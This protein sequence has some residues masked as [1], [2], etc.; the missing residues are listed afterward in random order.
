MFRD[1]AISLTDRSTR[2]TRRTRTLLVLLA[3]FFVTALHVPLLHAQQASGAGCIPHAGGSPNPPSCGEHEPASQADEEN[4]AHGAGN[5]IDLISGNKYQREVDLPALPGTLGLEI[6]RHYNSAHAGLDSPLGL[7]GRGWRLSYETDLHVFGDHIHILQADGR[8]LVF[9]RD[10]EQ[11]QRF[12]STDLQAG[13]VV[14][15]RSLFWQWHWA[16]GR[17]LDFDAAGKLVRIRL[18]DGAAVRLARG[19]RGELMKVTDPQ[20]RSLHLEYASRNHDGFRGVVAIRTPLGRFRYR[21]RDETDHPGRGNLVSMT[22]PDASQRLYHYGADEGEHD[23]RWPHHLT[24]ISLDSAPQAAH[25]EPR[26]TTADEHQADAPAASHHLIRLA[27][28]AYDEHGRAVLS[29]RGQPRQLDASGKPV[30]GTGIEQVE[31]SY[32]ADGISILRNSLGHI[33]RYRHALIHGQARLLEALGPGCARCGPT[34]IRLHYDDYGRVLQ[35]TQLDEQG[36]PLFSLH[37]QRDALGRVSRL[38]AQSHR[39]RADSELQLIARYEYEGNSARLRLLARPS[40]VADAEFQRRFDYDRH[41]QLIRLSEQGFSPLAADGTPTTDARSASTVQ[42]S[43]RFDYRDHQGRLLLTGVEGPLNS[44]ANAMQDDAPRI[45]L[46]W[47]ARSGLPATL[48][49]PGGRRLD[50]IQDADSGLLREVQNEEGRITRIHHDSQQRLRLL[51]RLNADGSQLQHQQWRYDA[52]DHAVEQRD[53][54]HPAASWLRQWNEHG[55]LLFHADAMG[56]LQQF[57]WDSENRLISLERSSQRMRQQLQLS[58]DRY[59]RLVASHSNHGGEQSW[60][61]D[62]RGRLQFEVDAAGLLHPPARPG[63]ALADA[64]KREQGFDDFGRL[65]WERSPDRGLVVRS[66]DAADRLVSMRDAGGNE[67]RYVHD[68]RGRIQDQ[69]IFAADGSVAETTEWRYQGSKLVEVIHPH[70]RERYRYDAAG[71]RSMRIVSIQ[72]AEGELQVVTRYQYDAAGRLRAMSLPDGSMLHYQ[73]NGQGQIVALSRT[74][75]FVSFLPALEQE[76]LIASKL[77]RDLI[78]PSSFSSGNGIESRFERS[79]EGVLTRVIH[80]QQKTSS[81]PGLLRRAQAASFANQ[82]AGPGLTPDPF[83]LLDRRYL[84]SAR[85]NLLHERQLAV[86]DGARAE[87]RNHAYDRHQQ[88]LSSVHH[89]ADEQGRQQETVWR[90]AYDQQ[91]RRILSQQGVHSQNEVQAKTE[92][93]Q[94]APASH[95]RSTAAQATDYDANGLPLRAGKR[96]YQWDARGQLRAVTEDG[97]LIARYRYD[98]RGLRILRETEGKRSYTVYDDQHQPLADI[99]EHGRLQRQYLWLGEIPLAIIDSPQGLPLATEEP[100]FLNQLSSSLRQLS[101]PKPTMYW[102]HTNHLGA[103]ELATNATGKVVWRARYA[104]FG[105]ATIAT[106]KLTLDL[107]LPGQLFDAETGL[108]YNRAR[109]Y[110][111]ASGQYLSPD[112]LGHP[113]GPNP[114]AYA[115]FNPLRFVDPEGLLLFAFDGTGRDESDPLRLSNVVHFRNAYLSDGGQSFYITGPGTLDPRTGIQNPW[116]LGGNPVDMLQSITGKERIE[117][118][119]LELQDH[120][121][122]TVD[123]EA[124][125]IDVIGF[126]RGAAQARDFANQIAAATNNGWYSYESR[127]LGQQCQRIN[128]RFMGLW[129]TVLSTHVGSYEL[130]IVEAFTHV[131]HAVAVNEYRGHLIAFPLES[132]MG[133]AIPAHQTRIERGFLGAHSDIGGGFADGELQKV[134]LNWMVEQAK[135]AEVSMRPLETELSQIAS[136]TVLHDHSTNLLSDGPR[137]G[138]E[139]RLI[140]YLDGSTVRQREADNL[141]LN[142]SQT[143]EFITY[144]SN[145]NSIDSVAGEVDAA[146]YLEWL[147]KNHYS[148]QLDVM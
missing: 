90:Y 35:R 62:D 79:S 119:I 143:E 21:H 61:Y 118:L 60:H 116:Y 28:Y 8:R 97:Q 56:F 66:Y 65:V 3:C 83:A 52:F 67:A 44:S 59:G 47:N 142:W 75:P 120:A 91:Q 146:S 78:G 74:T 126:S 106:E 76:Q 58:Y 20:G 135:A 46:E 55:Q 104:P 127:T 101:R 17:Q 25:K 14:H 144:R 103:P 139:D 42:R 141:T 50:L 43:I 31:L 111:P 12:L 115:A 109:Y 63:P 29:V 129:D 82:S 38:L 9:S 114:Y 27:T 41:G 11:P 18:P 107:R 51:E 49:L 19:P 64:G 113:D 112:P 88:L 133:T 128:F 110:D 2:S 92:R 132:I 99:D 33:T 124:I 85:G 130:G 45:S 23:P 140:R 94:F 26:A 7:L 77:E 6:V 71:R 134:A 54:L 86:H 70:Q 125:D 40:V 80:R 22:R 4:I 145:P 122:T 30:A 73:R 36:Q 131:A 24:G 105:A 16:D 96:S 87:T 5:P 32:P 13:V 72:R 138:S 15:Q 95:R 102:L 108:H 37:H 100:G 81:E 137:P 1:I 98:H 89:A 69:Q 57:S 39:H 53:H 121:D 84:W 93:K 148:V 147:E 117:N 123:W 48:S 136:S 68:E 34:N 10:L